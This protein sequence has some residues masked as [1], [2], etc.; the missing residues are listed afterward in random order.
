MIVK[1]VPKSFTH[2]WTFCG[3]S[4]THLFKWPFKKS[5]VGE[6]FLSSFHLLSKSGNPSHVRFIC[7]VPS[8]KFPQRRQSPDDHHRPSWNHDNL[9]RSDQ[10]MIGF[11]LGRPMLTFYAVP[12]CDCETP[13]VT[14][15]I[16]RPIG[17]L[18]QLMAWF[19]TESA[20]GFLQWEVPMRGLED[21]W[22]KRSPYHH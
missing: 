11:S 21:C 10:L 2:R 20:V 19:S 5:G 4:D 12:L 7:L 8:A 9:V 13:T 6:G 18:S 3:D 22:E 16:L 14:F 15:S 17:W 1:W